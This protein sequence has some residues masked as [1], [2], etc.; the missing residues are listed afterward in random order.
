MVKKYYSQHGVSAMLTEE[1]SQAAKYNI[2][3]L[4]LLSSGSGDE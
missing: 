2:T 3:A 1:Y 4:T